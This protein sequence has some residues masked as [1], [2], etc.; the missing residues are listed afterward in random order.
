MRYTIG[1][2]I[3]DKI[4][5][6][7]SEGLYV[8][9]PYSAFLLA[10]WGE[11]QEKANKEHRYEYYRILVFDDIKAATIYAQSLCRRFRRDDVGKVNTRKSN[12]IRHFF[13]IKVDSSNFKY[14]LSAPE[15]KPNRDIVQNRFN[16]DVET[17]LGEYYCCYITGL[18][19][20]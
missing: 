15:N 3:E 14:S 13:P 16:E 4:L 17:P 10:E 18:K 12:K 1:C 9:G 8:W 19:E 7:P 6:Q 20:N 2:R 5:G 11:K